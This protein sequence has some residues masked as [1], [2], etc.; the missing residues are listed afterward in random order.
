VPTQESLPAVSAAPA[1]APSATLAASAAVNPAADST[2][3]Y[4]AALAIPL[5]YL[6]FG[7][8]AVG[9]LNNEEGIYAEIAREMLESGRYVIPHLNGV[10]YIEKPPLLYYLLALAMAH[11]GATEL[12]LRLVPAAAGMLTLLAVTWFARQHGRRGSAVL[13]PL[14]LGSSAGFIAMSDVVMPDILL[15][16]LMTL[17]L[18]SVFVALERRHRGYLYLSYAFLAGA[19]LAKGLVAVALF[20]LV[21]AVYV[22]AAQRGEWRSLLRFVAMT[23]ALLVFFAVSAPWHIAAALEL[24]EFSWFYFVNEHLLRFLGMREPRDF[25]SGSLAYH[26]P[27]LVLF[28]FPWVFV[29]LPLMFRRR[30]RGAPGDRAA[31]FLWTCV[32]VPVVFF[33]LSQA[34]ANYYVVLCL[35]FLALL[36][37]FAVEAEL[38]GGARIRLAIAALILGA[39]ALALLVM[40]GADVDLGRS[41]SYV[42]LT[43]RSL[44]TVL[45]VWVALALLALMLV[46]RQRLVGALLAFA[47]TLLPLKLFVTHQLAAIEDTLSAR[48]LAGHI[49][50]FHGAAPVFVFQ[51]FEALSALP[52][53]LR[54][55]VGVIDSKSAALQFGRRLKGTT[56]QFPSAAKMV[57]GIDQP[58]IIVAH[59][60][61]MDSLKKTL[62]FDRLSEVRRFGEV[63]VF[64]LEAVTARR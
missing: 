28:F 62:M 1:A 3:A 20:S 30:E 58:A 18:L 36:T 54:Q 44:A 42:S 21:I 51:D 39:A 46:I 34:K 10:P 61:S 19:T 22:L 40:R 37:A 13:A 5:F 27:R 16:A 55:T 50:T 26:L 14:M 6:L 45:W 17:A 9:I 35:P 52:F 56:S 41:S 31:I 7:L 60:G 57:A 29:L 59:R 49:L 4:T 11:L 53:Y 64:K 63:S 47:L 15:C 23:P 33:S 48:A 24:P 43:D 2:V 32:L 12:V 8:D 25:Y 38:R